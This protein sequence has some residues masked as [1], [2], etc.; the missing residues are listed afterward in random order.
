MDIDIDFKNRDEL[1]AVL[2]P[3]IASRIDANGIHRHNVGV[4]FQNI[5]TDPLTGLASIDYK[6]AEELGYMKVD[7][8]NLNVYEGVKSNEHLDKLINQEP[9]WELLEERSVI[10]QLFHLHTDINTEVCLGMK[11]KTVEELAITIAIVRP[12]KQH[13]IGKSW[14]DIRAEIWK[15][16]EKYYFKKAHAFGY[17]MVI[18]VQLNLMVEQAQESLNGQLL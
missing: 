17:A 4:Y 9:L 8:L 15:P 13:L 1:I 18:L 7:L 12:G 2:K 5:P 3:K 14:S 6:R 11:P 16:T 10:E